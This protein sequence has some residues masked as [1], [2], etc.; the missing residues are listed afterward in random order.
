MSI[1]RI[2]VFNIS[3]KVPKKSIIPKFPPQPI[4]FLSLTAAL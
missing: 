4:G 3:K 2:A 1:H